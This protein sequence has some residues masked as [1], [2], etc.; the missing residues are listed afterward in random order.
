MPAK[1]RQAQKQDFDY[2]IK[3]VLDTQDDDLLT[4]VLAQNN[5]TQIST[6]LTMPMRAIDLLMYIETKDNIEIEKPIPFYIAAVFRIIKAWNQH[7]I[8]THNLKKIDWSDQAIVNADTYDDFRVAI[9]DPDIPISSYKA[10]NIPPP[11]P[12]TPPKQ[13]NI[14]S[15]FQKS[16]KRD[17]AHYSVLTNES[18][19]DEWKRSTIATI[20]AHG[21]QDVIYSTYAPSTPSEV[22]LFQ[23][24]NN[25]MYD[26]FNT[27]LKTPMGKHYVRASESTRDAQQVWTSYMKY[28]RTSSR[29][30]SEL[31]DLMSSLT[32]LRLT[33]SYKGTSLDFIVE[34]L[35]K[36]RQYED[37]TPQ[38]SHFPEP[39]K[40]AM[41]QNAVSNLKAFGDVKMAEN[42]EIAKQ[43]GPIP[44]SEYVVLLQN[45]AAN[46]DKRNLA[47]HLRN[48][49]RLIN[50][51]HF[52][53]DDFHLHDDSPPS[54]DQNEDEEQF[55]GSFAA[56]EATT[57]RPTS[58]RRRPT[59]KLE[60]W[61]KLSRA[62]QTAWD[63]LSDYAKWS[64]MASFK[65]QQH[66]NIQ[67]PSPTNH[68]QANLTQLENNDIEDDDVSPDQDRHDTEP[69]NQT[70]I[71][72]AKTNKVLPPSD[73]RMLLSSNDDTDLANISKPPHIIKPKRK[74]HLHE[75]R[76]IVSQHDNRIARN[77][78][79]LVD[80][81]ANGGLAGSD[82]RVISKTDRLV[83][84]SGLDNHEMTNLHIVTAGG[85]VS[86][87]RGEAILI[88]HQY[89]HIPNG[90]TIHS[91]IQVEHFGNDVD[92]K[93]IKLSK[94]KQLITTLDGYA[95][96]LNMINGLPYMPIR[97][98]S[99]QEFRTL[100]HIVLTSDVPWDP[101]IVDHLYADEDAW[102]AQI[103][104]DFG[105][106]DYSFFDHTGSLPNESIT[107][108]TNWHKT[109][110]QLL[111]PLL[112]PDIEINARVSV[113]SPRTFEKY[114]DYFLRAPTDVIQKT[115]DA[116]TQYAQSGWITGSIYDTYRSPFPALNVR[117]RNESVA[118]DTIFCDTPAID[119]GATCAQFFTGLQSKFCEVYGMKTDGHFVRTLMDTIRKNGAMDTLVSDRAQSEMSNKVKDVLRHLCIDAWQSEPHYQHQNQAE[120]RYKSVKHNV[121][122]VL[123][124]AAAPAYCWLLCLQY[125]CFIMNRLALQSLQWRTPYEKLH[126]ST[127]DISMIYRFK[128]Y[129]RVYYKRDESRGGANFPS[130]SNESVGR[131]V[132]FSEDV[133]HPMTYKVLTEDTLKVIHRSRI[134]LA[135]VDPNLRLDDPILPA[136]QTTTADVNPNPIPT[137]PEVTLQ[138]DTSTNILPTPETERPMANITTDDL[139]GR[140]YLSQPQEDGTRRRIKIIEQLDDFDNMIANDSNMIKFRATTDDGTIEEVITYNQILDKLEAEDG[141]DDEWHFKSILNHQGPLKPN[142]PDYKGSSWNV[143]ILWENDEVTW[144][145]LR[146]IAASDPVTCAIYAK[147]NQLLHLEGWTRFKRLASRQKKLLRLAH[148]AR[149][150]S[151]RLAPR[152]KFGVQVPRNH[153]QAMELDRANGNTLW[154]DAEKLEL[155]QI[156]EY[157]TFQDLGI[158]KRPAGYKQIRVHFVYDVKPTLKRKARLVADGQLTDTPIDSV[159]SSVVSIRGLKMCLFLAELNKLE[160]WCTDVGNAYL[161][162]YTEEKLFIIAGPE[163]GDLQGHTL[164]I[165]RALYGLK[166]SGLRW[167]ERFSDVLTDMG[168]VPSKAEDDI[169]MRNKKDHYEYI[170]RYVDD[171]AIISKNPQSIVDAFSKRYQLKLKGS[172]PINYHL[173]SDFYRDGTGTLCMSPTKYITRMMD[174]YER[175]FGSKPKATYSSPL[176]KGDHPELDTSKELNDDD[177]KKYQSLIG[178]LQWIITLGRLDIATAVMTMSSFRVAPRQGHLDR[179]KRIYGYLAKMKHGA[180]RFRTGA[181]DFSAIPITEYDW[182]RSIYGKVKELIP[183][184]AP[185]PYGPLVTITTY[186][187][188]NLCHDMITGRSVTGVLH[189]LNKSIID[190][191]TKK[192]PRVETATYGSEY[193]AARTATEQIMDLRTSLRYLGVN[194]FGPT[195]MFGDNSTVVNSSNTPKARLHK[196]HVILSFH[197]VREAIAA[198]ILHFIFIPG[199]DNPADIL[200]KHWGY[201]Q[202]STKLKALLFWHGDTKDI[203]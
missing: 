106:Y 134:K 98:F 200:S 201:Q 63:Q 157:E 128:F 136:E 22:A 68:L 44:Y 60:T 190:Y 175:M 61:S 148:Q 4:T 9:Y 166:S 48:K 30:D 165:S 137:S 67:Q 43:R 75:L 97:P 29:A 150:Q 156:D 188:A 189:L 192:Q 163:F 164:I 193:M 71:H 183:E 25:F 185:T 107:V 103:P 114:R 158:G 1:T 87:Q 69:S 10:I 13:T 24:Q 95:I 113:P 28:M 169:W 47:S 130:Q 196:R 65:P 104:N 191:Y 49:Q 53:L 26:V 180:S 133:G 126:G 20:Y 59:L 172:G 73:I 117:R 147:N 2:L 77:R 194:I 27:V 70:L 153:D 5:I 129:D 78:G 131:F 11:T 145:P 55:F 109:H 125:V 19:W 119:D 197:R 18:N 89:A 135:S 93:S 37:M 105:D 141:E 139:I 198:K 171:L 162:A 82:V 167:W 33:P 38:S 64:I 173:G 58:F 23:Q 51:V 184:D 94:G 116:T 154:R 121:N 124:M 80:R 160:S 108:E 199:S 83:D 142:H 110:A 46:Y 140:T 96:P 92:D 54:D 31:E 144:E 62:D 178:A 187:D 32:S 6:I 86:T 15:D 179:L 101:S 36:L 127:P 138:S 195:Y 122:K 100:P 34:W 88:M 132:G 39:M 152:Y 186:V 12:P 151:Y 170:A 17:K 42:I 66:R 21:C 50:E 161:E 8:S 74:C 84:V 182:E 85:V 79:A 76:Y 14:V 111:G 176:E 52:N 159:Y 35:D 7:L 123:N 118:T 102:E 112:A 3:T 72:A 120:R 90:K 181:P 99:D 202:I 168:F 81:G 40:K 115:F 56:Y 146:I 149:L 91:C 45:S 155:A 177:I 16:I 203:Q 41:L 174:N 57:S 143:Q